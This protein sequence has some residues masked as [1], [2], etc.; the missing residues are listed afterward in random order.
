MACA[1]TKLKITSIN[2]QGLKSNADYVA[3]LLDL[4]DI[5][6]VCEHWLSNAEK[7]LIDNLSDVHKPYFSPAEKGPSG[8]PFGGNCFLVSKR[9]RN[10]KILHEDPN[11]LAIQLNYNNT[12]M[13]I[14][15]VYL[16]CYQDGSTIEKYTTQL[17][18]LSGI[19]E[20]YVDESEIMILG[21]YQ[22]FPSEIYDLSLRNS[23]KRNPLSPHL[24]S[25]IKE[26]NL[27]FID[28]TRGI[29]PTFT[30]QHKTLPNQSYVDHVAVL[31]E[32][33][34]TIESCNIHTLDGN[35]ISDHQPITTT[36]L[37]QNN[38]SL[39]SI[40]EEDVTKH[41]NYVPK[42]CWKKLDF[43]ECY[44]NH[45]STKMNNFVGEI[46]PEV[47]HNMFLESAHAAYQATAKTPNQPFSK[48]W[49]TPELTTCKNVLS[50]HFN[51]W[52][53]EGFPRNADSV[54]FNRYRLAR[55]NFRKA[56]K[57]AQNR[58]VFSK[59]MK[60]NSLKKTDPRKYWSNMRK[61]KE[62]NMRRPFIVNNKQNDRDITNEFADHFNT[63]LNIPRTSIPNTQ[64]P[65]PEGPGEPLQ[66]ETNDIRS[67]IESLKKD[68]ACDT[69][70]ISAEH[71]IYAEN[72][73]LVMYLRD[74][75]TSVFTD[76]DTPECLSLTTLLPFVK[77]Y[78]KSLRSANNYR[79][80]SLIP[81]LTKLLEYLIL[82]KCPELAES[83]ASQF[84]FKTHSSTQHAEF[85]ISETIKDYNMKGSNVYLCSL[86]AEKAFDSCN[87]DVLF[88]KLFYEKNIPLQVVKVLKSL[89]TKGVYQVCYNGTISYKF[90]ASQGVFQGS[91]LSP[92]L[93]NIYT[94][95][96][97]NNIANS[98]DAGTTLHGSYTGIIA[99]ADDIIL[100]SSTI[101]GLRKL[102]SKCQE[103]FSSTAITLNVEKTEFITSGPSKHTHSAFI[104]LNGYHVHLQSSLKH[105]GFLWNTKRSGKA[106]LSD[107]NVKERTSKFWAVIYSLIRGGVRYCNPESISELYRTLAVPT[108]TYGLEL[109]SLTQSQLDYLDKEG[110]KAVKQLFNLSKYSK[111]YLHKLLSIASISTTINNNKLNLLTRLMQHTTTKSIILSILSQQNGPPPTSF[112]QDVFN[113][114][115]NAGNNFYDLLVSR[116][117]ERLFHTH[118]DIQ[119]DTQDTLQ[120]C[121]RNW[122]IGEMRHQFKTIME[123]HVPARPVV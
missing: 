36:L 97:L 37:F 89:Y 69:L 4:N 122:N 112:V 90:K 85:L 80:I 22:A 5:I 62:T 58:I 119:E 117:A 23:T 59:Y 41:G 100:I 111:K 118:D 30:Y 113:V 49:W 109:C 120:E 24:C 53:D 26:H 32:S 63:L 42:S 9:I 78:K 20:M 83:H 76:G 2:T 55:K 105:L 104:P 38:P 123:E 74:L 88:E 72:D 35:N 33:S 98:V 102:L 21:D 68:K 45:V 25:F 13:I 17:N 73:M 61:L 70:G 92:H 6:F 51:I 10:I 107:L 67:A 47:L 64:R 31:G 16:S 75:Y 60:I 46:T 3:H 50:L 54:S 114:V 110:R 79:G 95:E 115:N 52:R 103:Y 81:I 48:S 40:I 56:I 101:S 91:I 71:V 7:I 84:G 1:N 66:I 99:Y 93:Y 14:I 19:L 44:Q 12:N 82:H 77:S 121:L 15:G 28:I 8:R 94:E 106:C 116:R 43:I 29:G 18:T 108:L 27:E 65:L 96:L 11:I 39:T 86:D 57:A 34:L 87:W